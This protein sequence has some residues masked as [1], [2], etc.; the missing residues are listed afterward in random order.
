MMFSEDH[1][2]ARGLMSPRG[3]YIFEHESHLGNAPAH[4]LFE[5]VVVADGDGKPARSFSDYKS[6]IS[7]HTASLP[8]GVRYRDDLS[9]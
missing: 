2:A 6:R 9:V 5:R 3:L 8:R 1:S 4:A 7:V